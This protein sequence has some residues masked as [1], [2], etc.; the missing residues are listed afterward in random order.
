MGCVKASSAV[1]LRCARQ[2]MVHEA[3]GRLE[4]CLR[5]LANH[6]CSAY[7]QRMCY[8]ENSLQEH[9]ALQFIE[10]EQFIV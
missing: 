10:A 9:P 3:K 7:N 1:E 2:T 6:I 5:C 8:G 4:K